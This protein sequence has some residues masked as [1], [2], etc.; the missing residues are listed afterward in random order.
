[1]KRLYLGTDGK[2]FTVADRVELKDFLK[3]RRR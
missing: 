3:T 2:P 1:M